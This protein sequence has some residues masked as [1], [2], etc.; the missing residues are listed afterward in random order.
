MGA[1]LPDRFFWARDD[2]EAAAPPP[3]GVD[4]TRHKPSRA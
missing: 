1:Y 3:I 2:E 4:P